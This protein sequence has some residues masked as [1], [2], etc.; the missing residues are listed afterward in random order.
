[1][2]ADPA[3]SPRKAEAPPINAPSESV[4]KNRCVSRRLRE[5]RCLMPID[6][7]FEWK[8][9]K[10]SRRSSLFAIAMKDGALRP[11]GAVG[12]LKGP[13]LGRVGPHLLHPHHALELA[14]AADPQPDAVILGRPLRALAVGRADPRELLKPFPSSR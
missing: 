5:R 9:I 7:F 1:V 4:A 10:G 12:E 13:G 2:G 14:R 11:R 6:G 3:T 8:A